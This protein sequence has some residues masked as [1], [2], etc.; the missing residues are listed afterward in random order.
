MIPLDKMVRAA[1]I[2][3]AAIA[4]GACDAGAVLP[5]ATPPIVP[6][7]SA[8]PREVNLVARDYTFAPDA[9]DLAAGE[10]VLLHVING[11]LEIHEAVVGDMAVQDAWEVAEAATAGRP[12]G[13]T[14]VVSVPPEVSGLRIV[15][16]S[17]ERVDVV[18]TV[19]ATAAGGPPWIVGCHIPGHWARGMQI[20]I[21]WVPAT[22]AS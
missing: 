20:P 4:L 8:A 13:P 15:V 7:A 9:L 17:G 22:P 14:P 10:T 18:W 21:R 1:A 16:R 3:L 6:G 12:P 11:G 5:S 2:A 19:P